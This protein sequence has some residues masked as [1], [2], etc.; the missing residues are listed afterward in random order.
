M[1]PD[2]IPNYPAIIG[3][4][5]KKFRARA[6]MT[7]EDVAERCG[8]FRTYLSRIELGKANLTISVL[9]ALAQTL[10]VDVRELLTD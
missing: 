1:A 8:I 7:Q 9:T 4:Q 5:A 6:G 2:T 10:K 3:R